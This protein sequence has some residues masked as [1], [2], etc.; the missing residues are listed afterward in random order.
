MTF[1]ANQHSTAC[2]LV[3]VSQLRP[4]NSPCKVTEHKEVWLGQGKVDV[5]V[6]IDMNV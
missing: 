5:D 6:D 4:K 3:R 2:L 1:G